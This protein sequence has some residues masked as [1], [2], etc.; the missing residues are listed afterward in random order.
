MLD[1]DARSLLGSALKDVAARQVVSKASLGVLMDSVHFVNP[2]LMT[3]RKL[4]MN[5]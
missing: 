1:A 3:E 2:M 4:W 5:T